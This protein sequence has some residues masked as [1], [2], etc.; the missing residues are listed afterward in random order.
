MVDSLIAQWTMHNVRSTA[1][2]QSLLL[3]QSS[4]VV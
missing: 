3:T 2:V 1:T 4:Q